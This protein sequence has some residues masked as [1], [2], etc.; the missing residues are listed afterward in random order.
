MATSPCA[1][2]YLDRETIGKISA[3]KVIPSL[4]NVVK[5]LIE[6]SL[7]A[8]ATYIELRFVDYGKQ[9]IELSD[10]GSGIQEED[11]PHLALPH[12]TS[13]L[14]HYRDLGSVKTFGFR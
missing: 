8:H 13:K 5:E 3:G 1:I 10:D 2:K 7:D 9:L 6:N 11:F 4:A 12:Y 14:K